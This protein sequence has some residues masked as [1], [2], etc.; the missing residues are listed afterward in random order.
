MERV[1]PY[2][3]G[4]VH[5]SVCAVDDATPSEIRGAANREAPTGLDHGWEISLE[6]FASGERNGCPCNEHD[7][8]RHWLL[9]C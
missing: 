1:A 6:D 8:R 9:V 4:L 3:I 7:G 5:T 2:A